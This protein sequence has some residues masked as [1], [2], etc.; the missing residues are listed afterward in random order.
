MPE[1]QYLHDGGN[2]IHIHC[3]ICS[4]CQRP[5][6][7]TFYYRYKD[8]RYNQKKALYCESCYHRLA[9]I[10]FQC[11]KI[12]DNISLTYGDQIFHLNC[13]KCN[14]CHK[15][16][17]GELVFPYE[18]HI[19]CSDCYENVQNDFQPASS[20]VA[21]LRCSVCRK[22]F[23]PGDLITKHQVDRLLLIRLLV[24]IIIFIS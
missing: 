22:L 13:F 3:Y 10:C 9:P 23:Q 1:E 6:A 8:P 18:N 5:L 12:I 11:L 24:I 14:N 16:F 7:G 21:T 2:L 19:Y 15:S 17:K 20:I 4:N